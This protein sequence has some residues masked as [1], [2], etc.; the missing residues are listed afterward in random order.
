MLHSVGLQNMFSPCCTFDSFLWSSMWPNNA[1][2]PH[3]HSNKGREQSQHRNS[4]SLGTVQCH[5]QGH[6]DRARFEPTSH[7]L[8]YS[9]NSMNSYD[10]S[11]RAVY[12]TGG[13]PAS[14]CIL[15]ISS[16]DLAHYLCSDV[17]TVVK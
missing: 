2:P 3:H 1:Y 13:V 7:C 17:T 12:M 5:F 4:C 11:Y 6:N 16:E 15:N 10:C 9:F 8:L 14:E